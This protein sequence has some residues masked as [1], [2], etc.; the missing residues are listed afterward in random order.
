MNAGLLL[1]RLVVGAIFAA[2]GSQKL[3]GWFGGPG[4]QGTAGF[5]RSLEYRM[6]MAMGLMAGGSELFGGLAF[7]AGFA[8][9]LA[10]LALT[11]VMVNAV[12]VVHW[13]NGFFAGN[14]GYEFNLALSAVA[15]GVAATGPGRFSL[16]RA[17][18]WAD[19]LSGFWWGVGVALAAL[20]I[21]FVLTTALRPRHRHSMLPTP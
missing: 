19:N 9:P 17:L 16:D 1:I 15:V 3:F 11:V 12:R 8:T 6:P 14:G 21:G 20:A 13:Q 2:H 10:A 7:A 5:M 4:P 18:G